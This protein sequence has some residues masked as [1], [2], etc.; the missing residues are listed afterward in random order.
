MNLAGKG[1]TRLVEEGQRV[2]VGQAHAA[3]TTSNT[4][5]SMGKAM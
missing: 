3:R 5:T 4:W 2:A 1:F